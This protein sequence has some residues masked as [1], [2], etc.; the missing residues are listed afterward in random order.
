MCNVAS[1]LA[2]EHPDWILREKNRSLLL[3]R[4]G[5]AVARKI[6]EIELLVEQ[7]IVDKPRLARRSGGL[8]KLVPSAERIDERGLAHVGFPDYGYLC[9]ALLRELAP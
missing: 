3:G 8:G 2:E 5:V 6:D 7:E 1:W 9:A 4:G